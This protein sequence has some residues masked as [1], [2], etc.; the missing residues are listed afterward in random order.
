MDY[1]VEAALI[2][3]I[4][5][6]HNVLMPLNAMKLQLIITVLLIPVYQIYVSILQHLDVVILLMT[7]MITTFA[8]QIPA[9]VMSVHMLQQSIAV[10]TMPNAMMLKSAH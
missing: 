7:A 9:I 4:M 5:I 8:Q 3:M 10:Q 2:Q 1:A 6:V